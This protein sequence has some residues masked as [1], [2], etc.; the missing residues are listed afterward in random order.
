MRRVAAAVLPFILLSF[1]I[2]LPFLHLHRPA[3]DHGGSWSEHHRGAVIH[4]HLPSRRATRQVASDRNSTQISQCAEDDDE[5]AQPVDVAATRAP[6]SNPAPLLFLAVFCAS[7]AMPALQTRA[8]TE[9]PENAEPPPGF[10]PAFSP[11]GP[12]A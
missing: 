6:H 9:P 7:Q 11:R 3:D 2:D 12:P 1:L 10:L 4:S 8:V 5:D